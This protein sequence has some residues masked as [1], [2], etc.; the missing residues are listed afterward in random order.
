[1][2]MDDDEH[3]P[4]PGDPVWMEIRHKHGRQPN[5]VIKSIVEYGP[6]GSV[7][8]MWHSDHLRAEEYEEILTAELDGHYDRQ[9]SAYRI[10]AP[11]THYWR[12]RRIL[13]RAGMWK[14]KPRS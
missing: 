14:D 2:P 10:Y 9:Y 7:W 4:S 12:N 6:H 1:M 11:K 13:M 8:I 3:Q 5:G